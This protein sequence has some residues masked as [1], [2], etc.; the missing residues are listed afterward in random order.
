VKP[1]VQGLYSTT[2]TGVVE[3]G[4]LPASVQLNGPVVVPSPS[5]PDEFLPQH[6]TA[7]PASTAQAVAEPLEMLV[8]PVNPLTATGVGEQG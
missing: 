1:V 3:H 8:A 5:S 4:S 2:A 6:C 7:P